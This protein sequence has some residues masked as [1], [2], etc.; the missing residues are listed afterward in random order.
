MAPP[1]LVPG[2]ATCIGSTDDPDGAAPAS[3]LAST[4]LRTSIHT[5][6][7]AASST[8]VAGRREPCEAKTAHAAQRSAAMHG[9]GGSAHAPGLRRTGRARAAGPDP[10]E[11]SVL[12]PSPGVL[13]IRTW[14]SGPEAWTTVSR[15]RRRP[16]KLSILPLAARRGCVCPA[17]YENV[18]DGAICL[19][20]CIIDPRKPMDA[21]PSGR[22]ASPSRDGRV[23]L[24]RDARYQ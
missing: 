6:R 4:L 11:S 14:R 9:C 13:G 3:R 21:V 20:E 18:R 22:R 19:Q 16:M 1:A 10:A 12:S 17:R 7:T 5:A 24:S 8:P 23:L 2:T 15:A